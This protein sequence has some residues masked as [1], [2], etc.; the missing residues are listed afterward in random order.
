MSYYRS[1]KMSRVFLIVC[2]FLFGQML[3]IKRNKTGIEEWI[4]KK[5]QHRRSY[6]KSLEPFVYPYDLG[7]WQNIRQVINWSGPVGNGMVWNVVEGCDQ[8]TLTVRKRDYF[9]NKIKFSMISKKR[10][11]RCIFSFCM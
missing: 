4:L 3:S 2:V 6:N 9:Y 11:F 7:T 8:Y 5:A 1:L 10:I